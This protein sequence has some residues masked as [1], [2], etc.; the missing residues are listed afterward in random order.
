MFVHKSIPFNLLT[1][2]ANTYY[3]HHVC[4]LHLATSHQRLVSP[5][6]A[7]A[8]LTS[9]FPTNLAL[10]ITGSTS[11]PPLWK[12]WHS[13]WHIWLNYTESLTSFHRV[14]RAPRE[15]PRWRGGRFGP[16]VYQW[17]QGVVCHAFGG[18][19]GEKPQQ[20]QNSHTSMKIIKMYQDHNRWK[21]KLTLRST[22]HK[23]EMHEV[24]WHLW[25]VTPYMSLI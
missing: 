24:S 14:I 13:T 19:S 6:A 1:R 9:H 4:L 25:H 16:Q 18:W 17:E 10:Q 8:L 23:L 20:V 21:G 22:W 12:G 7:M 2:F 11:Q 5:K 15:G 3:F